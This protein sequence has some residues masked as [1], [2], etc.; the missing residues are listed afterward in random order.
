[1]MQTPSNNSMQVTAKHYADKLESNIIQLA[2]ALAIEHQVNVDPDAKKMT[3]EVIQSKANALL[4]DAERKGLKEL[5][6]DTVSQLKMNTSD[7]IQY[8][9]KVYEALKTAGYDRV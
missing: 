6:N 9:R 2:R 7:S 4:S 1:M 8:V 5:W 3:R